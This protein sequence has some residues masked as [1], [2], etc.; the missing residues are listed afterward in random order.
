MKHSVISKKFQKR[1]WISILL[2]LGSTGCISSMNNAPQ[3]DA[4]QSLVGGGKSYVEAYVEYRGPQERWAGPSTFLIHVNAREGTAAKISVSPNVFG[5]R[6]VDPANFQPTMDTSRRPAS[7]TQEHGPGSEAAP[8]IT[9]EAARNHLNQLA[10]AMQNGDVA[11]EGC[12]SPVR[13][14]LIRTDGAVIEKQGC[15]SGEGWSRAASEMVHQFILASSSV[16]SP[17]SAPA[18]GTQVTHTVA[19]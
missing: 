6:K 15:R 2:V 7:K 8:G 13:V 4:L 5:N 19:H 11:F 18:A 10:G 1:S 3:L 16:D 12:L 14:R 9:A 17:A